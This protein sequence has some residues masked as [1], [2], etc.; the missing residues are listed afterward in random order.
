MKPELKRSQT[1]S[2]L[3]LLRF[4]FLAPLAPPH[5][6]SPPPVRLSSRSLRRSVR[7]FGATLSLASS[8]RRWDSSRYRSARRLKTKIKPVTFNSAVAVP[9]FLSIFLGKC[10]VPMKLPHGLLFDLGTPGKR[11]PLSFE[12]T[13]VRPVRLFGLSLYLLGTSQFLKTR[14]L[15]ACSN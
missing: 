7:A 4:G 10:Q 5:P 2:P 1:D 11:C 15:Y 6:P 9:V 8:L 3:R 12:M 13:S 14:G